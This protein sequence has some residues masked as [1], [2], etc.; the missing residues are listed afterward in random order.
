[1][2]SRSPSHGP[3]CNHKAKPWKCKCGRKV[4]FCSC[5]HGSKY[6][7]DKLGDPWPPHQCQYYTPP[8]W[9]LER[10]IEQ[11][12][13][14]RLHRRRENALNRI[15]GFTL[16]APIATQSI[17]GRGV[18]ADIL[19]DVDIYTI[20]DIPKGSRTWAAALGPLAN[21][22][23]ARI[24]VV[25]E[26]ANGDGTAGYRFYIPLEEI[27]LSSLKPG[28]RMKFKIDSIRITRRQSQWYSSKLLWP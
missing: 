25:V 6:F 12:R 7:L 26:G 17:E 28:D 16:K 19:K 21:R 13:L 15:R 9:A 18:I 8:D 27:R 23:L 14:A 4:F 22:D 5:A 20:L 24:T 3:W 2:S 10:L 1:M 11:R